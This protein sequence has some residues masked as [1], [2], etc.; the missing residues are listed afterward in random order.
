MS[1][2]AILKNLGPGQR[3]NCRFIYGQ[4]FRAKLHFRTWTRFITLSFGYISGLRTGGKLS[5]DEA[6]QKIE[7]LWQSLNRSKKQLS[8][9][10]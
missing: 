8:L 6:T 5:E 4:L 3:E 2:A 1:G 10:P 7:Q 9:D